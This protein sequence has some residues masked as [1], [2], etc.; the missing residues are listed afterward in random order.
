MTARAPKRNKTESI[1]ERNSTIP[2]SS[3]SKR[4]A[5][6]SA[7]KTTDDILPTNADQK[8]DVDR[9]DQC[10]SPKASPINLFADNA[11]AS[12]LGNFSYKEH[13]TLSPLSLSSDSSSN[14][15]DDA[16]PD[17]F[18]SLLKSENDSDSEFDPIEDVR[19]K[20]AA[21]DELGYLKE[22]LI[23]RLKHCS[24]NTGNET[25]FV[26]GQYGKQVFQSL[27]TLE[28]EVMCKSLGAKTIDELMRKTI[29]LLRPKDLGLDIDYMDPPSFPLDNLH[30]LSASS[31]IGRVI[32]PD[33]LALKIAKERN[34][35]YRDA[36]KMM[37][38][39]VTVCSD[40]RTPALLMVSMLLHSLSMSVQ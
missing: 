15:D 16:A 28:Y 10:I 33:V 29:Y 5:D 13:K 6:S 39:G 25:L 2:G 17:T 35:S 38:N 11:S 8:A 27:G 23:K 12:H 18:K 1:Q 32:M 9:T 36:T 22:L 30:G 19:K 31:F 14:N 37:Y 3:Q 40:Y 34:I 24:C 26:L 20:K 21:Y 4:V 7:N